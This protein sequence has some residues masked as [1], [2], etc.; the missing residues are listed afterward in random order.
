MADKPRITFPQR[1]KVGPLTYRVKL[2]KK[3]PADNARNWGLC[4]RESCTIL[5]HERLSRPRF[6]EVLLHEV[7]HA[8]YDTSGLTL[9]DDCPEEMVVNDLSFALL[10]VLRDNPDL[11]AFLTAK[12]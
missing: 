1:I 8:C 10:G 11:V 12:E 9:K 2:W 6:R 5:I 4:D 7:M 3:R